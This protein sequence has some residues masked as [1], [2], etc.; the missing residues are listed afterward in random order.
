MAIVVCF[1]LPGRG[2][3]LAVERALPA[4]TIPDGHKLGKGRWG[5]A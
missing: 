4:Q 1:T 5:P 2:P 3:I